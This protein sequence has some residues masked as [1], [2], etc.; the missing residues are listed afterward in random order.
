MIFLGKWSPES[1]GDYCSGTNHV[2]P[3]DGHARNHNGLS[4]EQFTRYMTVQE[5]TSE[6]LELIGNAVITLANLEG[7]DAHAEAVKCRLKAIEDRK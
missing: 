7:L 3:T 5:L 1:V 2:L 6:G 4:V